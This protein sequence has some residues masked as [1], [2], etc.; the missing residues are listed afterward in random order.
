MHLFNSYPDVLTP[1]QLAD[2]LGICEKSARKLL[3][4]NAIGYKKCGSRYLIPKKCLIDFVLSARYQ[5]NTL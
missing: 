5:V 1:K 2:A 3:H 4:D